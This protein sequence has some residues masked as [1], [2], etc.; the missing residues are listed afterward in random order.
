MRPRGVGGV[1]PARSVV[2]PADECVGLGGENLERRRAGRWRLRAHGHGDV[3]GRKKQAGERRNGAGF[4]GVEIMQHD[5]GAE[6]QIGDG[7]A[8]KQARNRLHQ[9]CH[10]LRCQNG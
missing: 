2:V 4:Q 6:R 8:G 3:E 10:R 7:D 9:E 1:R 5:R